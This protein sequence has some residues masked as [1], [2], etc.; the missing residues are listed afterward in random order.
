MLGKEGRAENRQVVPILSCM[1]LSTGQVEIKLDKNAQIYYTTVCQSN[2]ES[3]RRCCQLSKE[4][5]RPADAVNRKK[6]GG[7]GMFGFVAH[8]SGVN[9]GK[10]ALIRQKQTLYADKA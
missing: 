7:E 9:P 4:Q 1:P 5:F 3:I 6:R 8:N 2:W 10:T